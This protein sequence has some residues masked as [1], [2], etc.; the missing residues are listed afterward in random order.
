MCS[1]FSEESS[2]TQTR[3][4]QEQKQVREVLFGNSFFFKFSYSSSSL[5]KF[6]SVDIYFSKFFF[7][8]RFSSFSL[9]NFF[10]FEVFLFKFFSFALF[11][12]FFFKSLFVLS[13]YFKI[14]TRSIPIISF[15]ISQSLI[16]RTQKQMLYFS[17]LRMS[18]G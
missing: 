6:L 13:Q 17:Y 9:L 16:Y 2:D 5:S 4:L 15:C 3:M 11:N 7:E 1:I 18:F 12:F 10:F 8:V 14:F